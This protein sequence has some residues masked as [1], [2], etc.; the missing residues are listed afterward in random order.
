MPILSCHEKRRCSSICRALVFVGTGLDQKSD[1]FKVPLL[2][3]NGKR[4]RSIICGGLV[5]VGT[6]RDQKSD[7]FKVPFFSCYQ[8]R[9]CSKG[10]V[11]KLGCLLWLGVYSSCLRKTTGWYWLN[12]VQVEGVIPLPLPSCYDAWL[13][14]DFTLQLQQLG[15]SNF[16]F[17]QVAPGVCQLDF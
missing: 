10:I 7:N 15:S 6:G 8:K 14:A 16:L 1:N 11:L 2:R 4:C 13:A 5:F 12:K 17:R 9:R 3:C